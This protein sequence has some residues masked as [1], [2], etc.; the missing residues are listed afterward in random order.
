MACVAVGCVGAHLLRRHT[1]T[2]L[3]RTG[4]VDWE[5]LESSSTAFQTD[6]IPSQLPVQIEGLC[7][8]PR[9]EK[10]RHHF[11]GNAGY[12]NVPFVSQNR[13]LPK[14]ETQEERI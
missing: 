1:A 13:A 7:L 8:T 9:H 4:T 3:N 10:T 14:A 11:E 2:S 12:A 6:A 5:V